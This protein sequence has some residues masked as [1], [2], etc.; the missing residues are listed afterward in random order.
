MGGAL[1]SGTGSALTG[2]PPSRPPRGA[3]RVKQ[4]SDE[5]ALE[6][7]ELEVLGA[8]PDRRLLHRPDT[9]LVHLRVHDARL[10]R[11]G[12]PGLQRPPALADDLEVVLGLA[13]EELLPERLPDLR[14][15]GH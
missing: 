6:R 2:R 10:E 8:A 3:A 12:L 15:G 11:S 1:A 7:H 4:R 5:S 14:V 13:L 9:A